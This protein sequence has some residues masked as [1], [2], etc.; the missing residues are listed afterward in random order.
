MKIS[1][2]LCS[3]LAAAAIFTGCA[4][5]S[6]VKWAGSSAENG[7]SNTQT[8]TSVPKSTVETTDQTQEYSGTIYLNL[9]SISCSGNNSDFFGITTSKTNFKSDDYGNVSVKFTE[10]ETNEKNSLGVIKVDA[11][12]ATAPITVYITGKIKNGSVKVSTNGTDIVNVILENSDISSSTYPCLDI[13]N[14]SDSLITLKGT[15]SMNDGRKYGTG[16]GTEYTTTSGTYIDDNGV[17]QNC[18][19]TTSAVYYGN[20]HKG[21]LYSKGNLSLEGTGS[22][23]VTQ[24]YKNCIGTKG[25]LTVNG[26]SYDLTSNGKDGLRGDA[27]VTVKAGIVTFSGTGAVSSSQFRKANGISID[28]DTYT[29]GTI[30]ISG[31]TI[32]ITTYNGKGIS[33]PNVNITGGNVS[34]DATGVTNFTNDNRAT[35]TYV[36]ADGVKYSNQSVTFAPEAIEGASSVSISGNAVVELSGDDDCINVSNSTGKFTMTGG[37]LYVYTAV[38]DGVDS[39]GTISIT[40]GNVVA[41]ATRGSECALDANTISVSGARVAACSGSTM[42]SP[43]GTINM[44]SNITQGNTVAVYSGSNLLYAFTVPKLSGTSSSN[45]GTQGGFGGS[46]GMGGSSSTGISL[47][48]MGAPGFSS[49]TSYTVYYNATPSGGTSFHGLYTSLPAVTQ[50]SGSTTASVGSGSSS[51]SGP[52]GRF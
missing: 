47:L 49:G 32:D 14:G 20:D 17:T 46:G 23:S 48:S 43:S 18:T 25:K 8:P 34:V 9:T 31:G 1:L 5:Q 40:G 15:N 12:Q 39:N 4:V 36:D 28:D 33:A 24:G 38:G 22:L 52:G 37:S 41:I 30:D 7:G 27:G 42:E 50:G 3:V 16:Y 21:T 35:S 11:A 19:V 2:L 51:G 44:T 26:G 13:V 6:T 45:T 29:S 10:D